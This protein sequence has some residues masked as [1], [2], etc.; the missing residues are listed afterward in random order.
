M[1]RSKI[2]MLARPI[3]SVSHFLRAALQHIFENVKTVI[4]LHT[5]TLMWKFLRTRCNY[6]IH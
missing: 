2:G 1:G 3:Q 5:I 4:H 6:I